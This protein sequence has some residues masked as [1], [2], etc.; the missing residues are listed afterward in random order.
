MTEEV[1]ILPLS[2]AQQR[3]WFLD[4]LMPGN[5]FYNLP[6]VLPMRGRVDPGVLERSL[7]EILRRHEVLRTTFRVVNGQPVQLIKPHLNFS[8]PVVDLR[9]LPPA[10]RQARAREIANEEA[11]RPFDLAQGPLLR[12]RLLRHDEME[13]VFLFTVHHIVFDDWSMRIFR[14]E[15]SALCNAFATGQPSPLPEL[16]VQYADF[17]VWQRNS[18]QGEA[19]ESQLAYWKKQLKGLTPLQLPSNKTRPAIQSFRGA[20]Q[21]LTLSPALTEALKTLSQREGVTL[22]MTLLAAFKALLFRYTEQEDIVVGLPTAGRNSAE[23]EK[24]IGFFV[25]T[26]VL[27]TDLS[28]NPTF[29]ELLG[30]VRE[31]SLEAYAHQDLPFEILVEKLQPE[32]QLS[33]NPLFQATFQLLTTRNGGGPEAPTAQ[34]PILDIAKDTIIFDLAFNLYETPDGLEGGIEYSTD[35]FDSATIT[36][37]INNYRTLLE[38]VIDNPEQRISDLPVLTQEEKRLLAEWNETQAAYPDEQCI[39]HLFEEQVARSPDSIVGVFQNEHLTYR[40]LNQRAN[41]LAH[42]LRSLGVGNEFLVGICLERSL[43]MLVAFLGTLKA[44]GAYVPLDPSYPEQRLAYMINDARLRVL[45]TQQ[46]LVSSLSG[47]DAKLV[48]L[49]RDWHIIEEQSQENPVSETSARNLAYVIY[50]SGSTGT[51]KGVLLEHR[52][53]CNVIPAQMK[54]FGVRS[55]SRILQFASFSFDASVSEIFMSLIGG[56]TLYLEKQ[57]SLLPGPELVELLRDRAITTITLTPSMLAA[58][59]GLGDLSTVSTIISAGEACAAEIVSEW[60]DGRRFFNAYGPTEATICATVARCAATDQKPSIGRP[61]ANT[62]VFILDQHLRQVPIGATGQLHIAGCNLA[63]GYLNRPALTAEKF[64]PHPFSHEPGA[65][66]YKTGDLARFLPN[67]EIEFLGRVDNQVKIRGFRIELEEIEA[68]LAQ[69]PGVREVAVVV[70]Q[71]KPEN[72]GESYLVAYVVPR[73]Q[74]APGLGEMRDYLRERLPHYMRPA[75]IVIRDSLPL[76]SAGKIDRSALRRAEKRSPES[77]EEYVAPKNE[78]EQTLAQIWQEVLGLEKV[79]TNDNFFDLGGH[80]L[81]MA[82]VHGR[83]KEMLEKDM[84]MV[85]LFRYPTINSLAKFI[86]NEHDERPTLKQIHGRAQKQKEEANKRR[87]QIAEEYS[88]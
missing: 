61:I 11:W 66:I 17:A 77:Q 5:T 8:M 60:A 12:A 85:D 86:S 55:E 13:Y 75:N 41:K 54:L 10:E 81:L 84:A 48:C 39:H 3:L 59:N 72:Q 42:Y 83:L 21:L 20:T 33:H 57:Q 63:R 18:L 7:N 32:R 80:S 68:T 14:E 1:F 44:G 4:Q 15:F 19:L 87:R 53:L 67:G 45:L 50:T 30:R 78:L 82:K 69:H 26:L 31:V 16:P 46:Q 62:Q 76:T 49:D 40:E 9:H 35:L 29:R 47:H 64:I 56:A 6:E 25:N 2:F 36:R 24:L 22:F 37:L 74:D 34:H 58:S 70:Q 51:P 23:I 88:R 65:R 71:D 52:G 28:G 79:S 38:G 43:E 27:R 73:E